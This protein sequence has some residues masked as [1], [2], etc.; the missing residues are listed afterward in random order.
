M[1]FLS[2][3]ITTSEIWQK[4]YINI[5]REYDE[6]SEESVLFMPFFTFSVKTHLF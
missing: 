1:R 2:T 4:S 3:K 5:K 6:E